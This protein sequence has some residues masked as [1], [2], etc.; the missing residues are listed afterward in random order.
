ML[1][2]T[3]GYNNSSPDV[4]S[5]ELKS[6]KVTLTYMAIKIIY[7]LISITVS[8]TTKKQPC[9]QTQRR[10]Q[11]NKSC[12]KARTPAMQGPSSAAKVQVFQK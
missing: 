12:Q 6:A 7:T 4:R 5:N 10:A 1:T 11:R 3:P 2:V 8:A 9:Q